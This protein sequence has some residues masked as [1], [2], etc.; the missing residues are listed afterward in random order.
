MP[1]LK[2]LP[3]T[4]VW[5]DKE[6]HRTCDKWKETI[7]K[8]V[9][10]CQIAILLLSHHYF[11][12]DG[13]ARHEADLLLSRSR[14]HGSKCTLIPLKVS[15]F[16]DLRK[17]DNLQTQLSK[18]TDPVRNWRGDAASKSVR[19]LDAGNGERGSFYAWFVEELLKG[20]LDANR[21]QHRDFE[22]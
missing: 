18:Y 17:S 1:H 22:P 21:W 10:D 19:E 16:A 12:V 20:F 15:Q 11:D 14:V 2:Q 5:W 7:E 4:V 13:F 3:N 9:E 6:T 8:A